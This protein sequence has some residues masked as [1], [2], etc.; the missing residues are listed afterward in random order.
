MTPE[1]ELTVRPRPSKTQLKNLSPKQ[2]REAMVG[3]G[4]KEYRGDQLAQWLFLHGASSFDEMTSISK[5]TRSL[6]SQ[7]CTVE[8]LLRLEAEETDPLGAKRLLWRLTDD[9]LVESVILRERDHQTLCVSTQVGCRMGCRFCRT[10]TLGLSRNLTQGEIVEQL[11]LARKMVPKRGLKITNV[12]FMGMGEPLDNE[13]NVLAALEIIVSPKF[14][15][16]PMRGVSLSTVGVIP[17][18][19]RIVAAGGLKGR[20]TISLGSAND[21]LRSQLMPSNLTWPLAKLK[22][23]LIEY[24]RL[25]RKQRVTIAYVLLDGVNDSPDQARELSRFMAGLK[26]K[27]NLI[28]FNPWPDAPFNRPSAEAVETFKTV[29]A[30]KNYAVQIRDTK[31][32]SI[33]AACGL[34]VADRATDQAP[35]TSPELPSS[36]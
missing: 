5:A 22:E 31:G 25:P 14:Q 17:A 10:G 7:S 24:Q 12:V 35:Q 6:I 16:V 34:L 4:E 1:V 27:V 15:A 33:N 13:K 9:L 2:M 29:L 23:T 28:P 3:L 11:I 26:T 18:L 19:D 30:E 20:F 8:P 32:A 21:A 36:R